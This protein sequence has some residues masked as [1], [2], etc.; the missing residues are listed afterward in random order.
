MQSY[1]LN[2]LHL[3]LIKSLKYPYRSIVWITYPEWL[4]RFAAVG[5]GNEIIV[6]GTEELLW[7]SGT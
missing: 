4:V 5:G 2:A 3:H 7:A 6:D 1:S